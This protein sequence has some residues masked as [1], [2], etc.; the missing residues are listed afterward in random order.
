M[1]ERKLQWPRAW[2]A[3]GGR[4]QSCLQ[5]W[6]ARQAEGRGS[7]LGRAAGRGQ[8]VTSP[9][10]QVLS[11]VSQRRQRGGAGRRE[12]EREQEEGEDGVGH[13]VLTARLGQGEVALAPCAPRA[14][15][16]APAH[17]AL[18]SV[19]GADRAWRVWA[20]PRSAPSCPPT[21][22][23][24]SRASPWAPCGASESRYRQAGP[25][26]RGPLRL[27]PPAPARAGGARAVGEE[28]LVTGAP[29]SEGESGRWRC[30]RQ[31]GGR[32]ERLCPRWCHSY[33]GG[34][35]RSASR[36]CI[37]L[38]SRASTAGA[39]TGHTPWSWPA[40]TRTTW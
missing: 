6:G 4:S 39:M 35:R 27:G 25:A 11:R 28:G 22:T 30:G 33:L 16:P 13:V 18:P 3:Q 5:G 37:G 15:R 19:P 7:G 26:A 2:T 29:R 31:P 21:T 36:G 24:P 38:T 34:F 10:S 40:G 8:G 17:A 9:S 1:H 12:A 23:D 32:G 14:P 20:A